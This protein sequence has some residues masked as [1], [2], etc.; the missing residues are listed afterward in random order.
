MKWVILQNLRAVILD[1]I[2][3]SARVRMKQLKCV[4]CVSSNDSLLSVDC[5][6]EGET[7]LVGTG[8]SYVLFAISSILF[9]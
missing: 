5:E 9:F 3:R 4:S 7:R 8:I 6:S 2:Q 1:G